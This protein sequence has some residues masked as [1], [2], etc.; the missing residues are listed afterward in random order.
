MISRAVRIVVVLLVALSIAWSV[1]LA[2]NSPVGAAPAPKTAFAPLD[3][4]RLVTLD[5]ASALLGPTTSQVRSDP[6]TCVY[7]TPPARAVGERSVAL[8]VTAWK[9]VWQDARQP[10]GPNVETTALPVRGAHCS[11][12]SFPMQPDSGATT[13]NSVVPFMTCVKGAKTLQVTTFGG[14][15]DP[16]VLLSWVAKAAIGRM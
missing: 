3:A 7:S 11:Y 1:G 10:T 14:T 15:D 12:T 16:K 13:A 9:G 6:P 2:T 8:L 5:D 4:C